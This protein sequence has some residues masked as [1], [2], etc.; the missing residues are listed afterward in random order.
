MAAAVTVAAAATPVAA[1]PVGRRRRG[2]GA[3]ATLE[4]RGMAEQLATLA[5]PATLAQRVASWCGGR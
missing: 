3:R 5:R 1:M 2:E 4:R